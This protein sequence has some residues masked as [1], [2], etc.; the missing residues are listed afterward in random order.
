METEFYNQA[1]QPTNILQ[2]TTF[3]NNRRSSSSIMELGVKVI[4]KKGEDDIRRYV[5]GLFNLGNG[6]GT[7]PV[8]SIKKRKV[9]P[10][11]RGRPKSRR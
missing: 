3:I 8:Q 10:K 1:L 9:G 2:K 6:I 11:K 4:S 7:E 5:R